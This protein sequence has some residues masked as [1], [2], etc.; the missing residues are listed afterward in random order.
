[1]L[2]GNEY[3]HFN[4]LYRMQSSI[5][6]EGTVQERELAFMDL[7]ESVGMMLT[8]YESEVKAMEEWYEAQEKKMEAERMRVAR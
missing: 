4:Q 2:D 6:H 8:K 5:Y 7:F 3:E 1:M